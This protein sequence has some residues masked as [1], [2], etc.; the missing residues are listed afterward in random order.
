MAD[1][2]LA[3]DL[4]SELVQLPR[5]PLRNIAYALAKP[6]WIQDRRIRPNGLRY[7]WT[8]AFGVALLVSL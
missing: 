5:M 7:L 6:A 2:Q 1:L 4:C 3:T 8:D